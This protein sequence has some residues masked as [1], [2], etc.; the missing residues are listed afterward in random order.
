MSRLEELRKCLRYLSLDT[1]IEIS[2]VEFVA[3]L[4]DLPIKT[5][6]DWLAAK[7]APHQFLAGMQAVAETLGVSWQD[8]MDAAAQRLGDRQDWTLDKAA[9]H[10][11]IWIIEQLIEEQMKSEGGAGLH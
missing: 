2:E 3:A 11:L 6:G 1:T 4:L 8:A 10:A 5:A 7:G 9:C